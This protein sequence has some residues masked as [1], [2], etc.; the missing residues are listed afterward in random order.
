MNEPDLLQWAHVMLGLHGLA[1]IVVNLTPSP[2]DDEVLKK[3]Y[4]VLEIFAGL[5]L[6]LSKR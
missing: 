3:A 4:K 1:L 2:R 6:P 5:V